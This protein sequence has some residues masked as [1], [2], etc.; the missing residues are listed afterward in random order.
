MPV[1]PRCAGRCRL[2]LSAQRRPF[3]ASAMTSAASFWVTNPGPVMINADHAAGGQVLGLGVV[4]Q[5]HDRQVALQELLLI[6]G[7]VHLP[8]LDGRQHVGAEVEGREVDGLAGRGDVERRLGA[9]GPSVSRPSMVGSDCSSAAMVACMPAGSEMLPVRTL[10]SSA[11][12]RPMK[13]LQRSVSAWLPTS[14]LKHRAF[15]TPASLNHCRRRDR[16]RTR[17]ARRGRGSPARGR[18]RAR[19]HRDDRD[20]RV[21]GFLDG[22]S[23]GV[24]V[25]DRDHE[26]VGLLATAASISETMPGMS[27][28]AP[29]AL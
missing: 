21:D 22:R 4:R 13:P 29:G 8:V 16:P 9:D 15:L 7:E 3:A 27:L 19:V 12:V 2:V 11:P 6:D 24:R 23:E 14:W 10:P 1:P 20:A 26:P 28:S 17:S 18:R 25:R 5:D